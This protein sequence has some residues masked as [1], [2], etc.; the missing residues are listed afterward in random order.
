M[1]LR[2]PKDAVAHPTK[3]ANDT[4]G[5]Y[6]DKIKDHE[7]L[8]HQHVVQLFQQLEAGDKK[9]LNELVTRNLKLVVA[10]A[11]GYRD[12]GVDW[13]DLLQEGNLGLIHAIEKFEWKRG[14]KFSTYATWWI[15][16]RISHFLSTQRHSI[17]VPT[18]AMRL[19]K[20][21]ES[22]IE[23]LRKEGI[24]EPSWERIADIIGSS[25]DVVEATVAGS[26]ATV[27]LSQPT[28]PDRDSYSSDTEIECNAESSFANEQLKVVLREVI[29][30][31]DPLDRTIVQLRLGVEI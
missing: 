12:K 26:K 23:S 21:I 28:T 29:N 6:L 31:L 9:A 11:R 18:H 25:A 24:E 2:R 5:W 3:R 16:Q 1:E 30:K 10:V 20:H 19:K 7:V 17:R 13:E 4:V 22:T 8:T 15:R 14:Y 27:S